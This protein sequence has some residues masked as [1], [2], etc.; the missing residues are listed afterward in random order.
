MS[1]E[2]SQLRRGFGR[3]VLVVLGVLGGFVAFDA[4]LLFIFFALSALFIEQTGPYF[5]LVTWVALPFCAVAGA[6]IAWTAYLVLHDVAPEQEP[7][8]VHT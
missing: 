3:G 6:A 2:H 1:D 5:G 8:G 4:L 7:R